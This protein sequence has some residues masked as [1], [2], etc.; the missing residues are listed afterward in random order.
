MIPMVA[1][2]RA[3]MMLIGSWAVDTLRGAGLEVSVDFDMFHSRTSILIFLMQRK[4][5]WKTEF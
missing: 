4:A 5:R 3:G 1:E 2:A